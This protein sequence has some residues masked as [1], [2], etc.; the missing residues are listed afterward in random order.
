MDMNKWRPRILVTL[1]V[2][3]AAGILAW[4]QIVPGQ[5]PKTPAAPPQPGQVEPDAGKTA[6]EK[7]VVDSQ[8]TAPASDDT[9]T[10]D[11]NDR[12]QIIGTAGTSRVVV[13]TTVLDPDGHGYVRGLKSSDFEVLDNG[14]PQKIDAELIEQPLSV[15]LAVQAN[16]EV[17]GFLPKL[18]KSANLLHGLVTGVEGDVAILAFDHRM[19]LLQDFTNDPDKL[20]DAMQHLRSGST[21][22][23]IIDAVLEGDR[24]L[25]RHDR[26][27]KRRRV[28][29]LISRDVNNGSVAKLSETVR[30]MQF[31]N[32]TVYCVDISKT[33]SALT[34]DPGYPRPMHGGI[35]AEAMPSNPGGGGPNTMT[36]DAQMNTG[37]ALE[38]VP[39]LLTSIH[40]LFKKPPARAF[41]YFTGGHV[42][43]FATS[44]GLEKAIADIGQDLNN[45][46]VLSY[47]LTAE[48][49][50]EPGFH[51]IVVKVDRPG[52]KIRTRP[53]YWWGG[54]KIE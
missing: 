21:R 48:T 38:L 30:D 54:G 18:R 41:T 43:N 11:K 52:L 4:A 35:P 27:N 51:N 44:R 45:Q 42:Y 53:G 39:P 12:S 28:V 25:K 46:Y 1:S 37:N 47:A 26:D 17:E 49:K 24:M 6:T 2:C 13:P 36:N 33:L 5:L 29:I 50:S 40:D 31:D 32:V 9:P 19:M 22:S 23:A 14:T 10:F 34:Q 20:D 3:L 16:S 8:K 15:V 7:P